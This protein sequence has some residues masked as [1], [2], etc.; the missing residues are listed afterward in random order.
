MTADQ[1][2]QVAPGTAYS[3]FLS[4]SREDRS[5]AEK[6]VRA[7]EVRGCKVWWDGLLEGGVAFARTTETA[8][9]GADA[10]VVL[11]SERAIESHWVRD[12]AT[13]GRDRQRLVPVTIDGA[14]PPLGFRQFQVLDLSKWR[15]KAQS[16][17]ID[18]LCRAIA[19]VA[20]G[21]DIPARH[22]PPP[23]TGPSRRRLLAGAAAGGA[24]A[25]AGAGAWRSGLFSS[26]PET[27]GVAVLPFRN[28]S[29]DAA[30][31]YFAEGLSEELRATLSRNPLL[32]VAAP[33]SAGQFKERTEEAG[34]IAEKLGVSF[35]LDGSVRRAGDTVRI[36]ARLTDG[37]TGFGRWAQ[38]FER[39]LSDIFAVQTE[40]ATTVAEA[41][42]AQVANDADMSSDSNG[43]RG[44]AGGTRVVA[45]YDDYLRG[46]A[47]YDRVGGESSDREALAW[48]DKSIAADSRYAQAHAARARTLAV[49]AGGTTQA[50]ELRALY[51]AS[52]AAAQKAVQLAP[53]L[54]DAHSALGY[55]LTR[56]RLDMRAA[57]APFEKSRQFG[58]GDA[59]V[60]VRYATFCSDIGRQGDALA[61]IG[62]AS[63]LD[64]L[65]PRVFRT[66]AMVQYAARHYPNSI[67]SNGKALEMNP[68][69]SGAH[70]ANGAALFLLGDFAKAR[71]EYVREPFALFRLTGLAI[72]DERQGDRG[73]AAKSLAAMIAEYGDNGLYQKAQILAQR[74]ELDGAMDALER[75]Y[76][77]GDA[78]LRTIRND[79]LIDPIRSQA[80]FSRLLNQMG[81]D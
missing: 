56:G 48:F 13:S 27:N 35:V 46:R 9:D 78:G 60:L 25:L 14:M 34:A 12:E 41:L 62:R 39:K 6:L 45:A 67:A 51:E 63:K 40:I 61:A 32:L 17:E 38:S 71:A 44:A 30:Q 15:A 76:E 22:V 64:P 20:G 77:I 75:G 68:K 72:V 26:T 3:V 23:G 81:F 57:R 54:A 47:A 53:R 10:V 29:G 7:L 28:L 1:D 18:D 24:L 52:I 55:A 21:P 42:A 66:L 43:E 8:L 16:P 50:S 58:W 36:S 73:A 49:I 5:F 33:T 74:G 65:N 31:D 79:P 80:R 2:S 59:D 11:W 4:Y 69:M 37:K 70:A 19:I